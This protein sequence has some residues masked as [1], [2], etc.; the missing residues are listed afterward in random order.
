MNIV[1]ERKKILSSWARTVN[2]TMNLNNEE[3]FLFSFKTFFVYVVIHSDKEVV[4]PIKNYVIS[5]RIKATHRIVPRLFASCPRYKF[6]KKEQHQKP[7]LKH[8][9]RRK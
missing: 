1:S 9:K 3:F 8:P 5:T 2:E 7:I 4:E 6:K